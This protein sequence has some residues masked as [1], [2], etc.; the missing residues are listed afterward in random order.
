MNCPL[1]RLPITDLRCRMKVKEELKTWGSEEI[2]RKANH[3][4]PCDL[5]AVQDNEKDVAEEVTRGN[6]MVEERAHIPDA[7]GSI[8]APATNLK[9]ESAM[10]EKVPAA[11]KKYWQKGVGRCARC[12]QDAMLYACHGKNVCGRCKSK[13]YTGQIPRW[14]DDVPKKQAGPKPKQH[15]KVDPPPDSTVKVLDAI[16]SQ[17]QGLITIAFLPKDITIYEALL[18]NAEDMRRALDQQILWILQNTLEKEIIETARN[19]G[20]SI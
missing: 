3:H 16:F 13:V 10:P 17:S 14:W 1:L 6:S 18:K 4:C 19:M 9:E 8:P 2:A 15:N 7:A 5:R 12:G 20:A 11:N